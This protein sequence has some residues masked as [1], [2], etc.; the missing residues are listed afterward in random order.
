MTFRFHLVFMT[1]CVSL[2]ALNVEKISTNENLPKDIRTWREVT[3]R[4]RRQDYDIDLTQQDLNYAYDEALDISSQE[5]AEMLAEE[6]SYEEMDLGEEV[7][8]VR[9]V[10]G[11]EVEGK[12]LPSNDPQKVLT[13]TTRAPKLPKVDDEISSNSANQLASPDNS[14]EKVPAETFGPVKGKTAESQNKG[15]TTTRK[16][17]QQ[18]KK[19]RGKKQPNESK[20]GKEDLGKR[21]GPDSIVTQGEAR[22]PRPKPETDPLLNDP[23]DDVM[24]NFHGFEQPQ[25]ENSDTPE[26]INSQLLDIWTDAPTNPGPREISISGRTSIETQNSVSG[27]NPWYNEPVNP[28]KADSERSRSAPVEVEAPSSQQRTSAFEVAEELLDG[29]ETLRERERLDRILGAEDLHVI[30]ENAAQEPDTIVEET[31]SNPVEAQVEPSL[32]TVSQGESP[33]D[34]LP[35]REAEHPGKDLSDKNL[36]P[37]SS[38]ISTHAEKEKPELGLINDKSINLPIG[39]QVVLNPRV[40]IPQGPQVEEDLY[41][42]KSEIPPGFNACDANQGKFLDN[43]KEVLARLCETAPAKGGEILGKMLGEKIR[44]ATLNKSPFSRN[45]LSQH[46][47]SDKRE[48]GNPADHNGG[49]KEGQEP[50][51]TTPCF[52]ERKLLEGLLK[53]LF[54]NFPHTPEAEATGKGGE[55]LI[56]DHVNA[57]IYKYNLK[58]GVPQPW[59]C[60]NWQS[61]LSL[62][63]RII[64]SVALFSILLLLLC[65]GRNRSYEDW[66][67]YRPETDHY[68]PEIDHEM[69]PL[70]RP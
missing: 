43:L 53:F 18:H 60:R 1:I 69:Y 38:Q 17:Q 54:R 28:R 66:E 8:A 61:C 23:F 6:G 63:D 13:T 33:N 40:E 50:L 59:H 22:P 30:S 39:E 41:T 5:L 49:N 14:P 56:I 42:G 48:V 11:E 57:L 51:N 65:A 36:F 45:L 46:S 26:K 16:P 64:S 15:R 67:D 2:L 70:R 24:D 47:H 62:M 55:F 29:A 27:S 19:L 10:H 25:G 4:V 12:G 34:E 37:E 9:A 58:H 32:L 7:S 68:R 31:M 3:N 21:K 35:I 52:C 20:Q 44:N